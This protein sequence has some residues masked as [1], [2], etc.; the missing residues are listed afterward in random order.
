MITEARKRHFLFGWVSKWKCLSEVTDS[1]YFIFNF[2]ISI[3]FT[4]YILI[5]LTPI[6][7]L[8]FS[9]IHSHL[10]TPSQHHVLVLLFVCFNNL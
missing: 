4:Q 10:P 1:F 5:I 8:N 3:N 7:P 9:S 2:N 6:L